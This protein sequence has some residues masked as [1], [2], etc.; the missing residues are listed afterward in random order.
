MC[1]IYIVFCVVLVLCRIVLFLRCIRDD[2]ILY[3]SY[4]VF[5][6]TKQRGLVQ[7]WTWS[8]IGGRWV[9]P[10]DGNDVTSY[11]YTYSMLLYIVLCL[12]I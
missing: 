4:V 2:N 7:E 10:A 12:V 9:K 6:M 1:I 11:M 3:F 8:S 5:G